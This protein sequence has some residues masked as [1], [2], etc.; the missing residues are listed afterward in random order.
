MGKRGNVTSEL[1]CMNMQQ[2]QSIPQIS[3]LLH[4]YEYFFKAVLVIVS[5]TEIKYYEKSDS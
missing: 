2:D 5:T 4:F 1:L 3:K